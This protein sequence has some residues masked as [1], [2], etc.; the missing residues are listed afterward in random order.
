MSIVDRKVV[1]G[2]SHGPLGLASL[3][4][5][6]QR[7]SFCKLHAH[8]IDNNKSDF[9]TWSSLPVLRMLEFACR[10]LKGSFTDN[11]LKGSSV[12]SCFCF[13]VRDKTIQVLSSV[14]WKHKK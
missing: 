3:N 5:D 13:D 8:A 9:E 4:E 7:R 14:K 10:L 2:D 11:E 12:Y 6:T 1:S